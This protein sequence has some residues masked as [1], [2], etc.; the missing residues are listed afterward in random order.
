MQGSGPTSTTVDNLNHDNSL[1][2]PQLNQTP[3]PDTDNSHTATRK[4]EITKASRRLKTYGYTGQ[5]MHDTTKAQVDAILKE[6][7]PEDDAIVE[8]LAELLKDLEKY[9][10]SV[11]DKKKLLDNLVSQGCEGKIDIVVFDPKTI[12]K[13]RS[14]V[15]SHSS[16]LRQNPNKRQ[17]MNVSYKETRAIK[18]KKE[19][20][21]SN[22]T[23]H[24]PDSHDDPADTDNEDQLDAQGPST[25]LNK[26]GFSYNKTDIDLT[27]LSFPVW[28]GFYHLSATVTSGPLMWC[29]SSPPWPIPQV[30]PLKYIP[31]MF[32]GL[33][34]QVTPSEALCI[35]SFAKLLPSNQF[36]WGRALSASVRNIIFCWVHALPKHK[37]K[38]SIR[39]MEGHVAKLKEICSHKEMI[40]FLKTAPNLLQLSINNQYFRPESINWEIIEESTKYPWAKRSGFFRA[41]HSMSCRTN[42]NSQWTSETQLRTKLKNAFSTIKQILSDCINLVS[43]N[44]A[45]VDIHIRTTGLNA[46]PKDMV[47]LSKGIGWL[48]QQI[49]VH[50]QEEDD[51]VVKKVH[52]NGLAWLQRRFMQV[53][54][55][56]ML[57]Y[58]SQKYNKKF[59]S[60]ITE[61][62]RT[63]EQIKKMRQTLHDSSCLNQLSQHWVKLHPERAL[64]ASMPSVTHTSTG[65]HNKDQAIRDA[66]ETQSDAL[67]ALSLFLLYGTAG[68][69]HVWTKRREVTLHDSSY[70]I[71]LTSILALRYHNSKPTD[72]GMFDQRAWCR[73][74]D[75]LITVVGQFIDREGNFREDLDCSELIKSFQNKLDQSHLSSLFILDLYDELSSPGQSRAPDGSEVPQVYGPKYF[76]HLSIDYDDEGS[77]K[78]EGSPSN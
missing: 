21:V 9:N 22:S 43:Y 36:N 37:P 75:H 54:M 60:Y 41:L 20:K 62:D 29:L 47:D 26:H 46:V 6:E 53:V 3:T 55:G 64:K 69:F 2:T 28:Q 57:I 44:T 45:H 25:P 23:E 34:R 49:M 76:P 24:G 19:S 48:Y 7:D 51:N 33:I 65:K 68:L 14:S 71:N 15:A 16:P 4:V 42:D 77:E 10:Q 63:H 73:L 70:L 35:E 27:N 12:R 58:E 30:L 13:R 40:S 38:G 11:A 78:D 66:S 52:R 59:D 5:D 18:T 17:K 1:E 31:F 72:R 8:E 67:R 61:G 56:V 50:G 74:D 32:A 39:S